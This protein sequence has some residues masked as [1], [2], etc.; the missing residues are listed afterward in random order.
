MFLVLGY[1]I[2]TRYTHKLFAEGALVPALLV[3]HRARKSK[4]AL[5]G[6]GGA[7]GQKGVWGRP[8]GNGGDGG[9]GY[10]EFTFEGTEPRSTAEQ[11]VAYDADL[12]KAI[13]VVR[14][15]VGGRVV[16]F[17][18]V[19]GFDSYGRRWPGQFADPASAAQPSPAALISRSSATRRSAASPCSAFAI[20]AT[21]FGLFSSA[22]RF[23]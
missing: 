10:V 5:P 9:Q 19:G 21:N 15:E 8:P 18:V 4:P 3:T 14:S 2:G 23:R 12:R 16:R 6:Q 7:G 22:Q 20:S 1:Q 11:S 13:S 17:T